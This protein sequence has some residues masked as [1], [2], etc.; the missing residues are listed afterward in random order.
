MDPIPFASS[1]NGAALR[2]LGIGAVLPPETHKLA[3]QQAAK[4]THKNEAAS[5]GAE[6]VALACFLN[7]IQ[8]PNFA[9]ATAKKFGYQLL[10]KHQLRGLPMD[11]R[12]ET[13]LPVI[14]SLLT[15]FKTP[16]EHCERTLE[17]G[18]DTDTHLALILG[19]SMANPNFNIPHD[20]QSAIEKAETWQT[21]FQNTSPQN[22]TTS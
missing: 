22:L 14:L 5:L 2:G 1:G 15:H 6:A 4:I 19:I 11:A 8:T 16:R 3:A 20:F 13:T 12:C 18:G 21:E 9:Q 17:A 10:E 7:S